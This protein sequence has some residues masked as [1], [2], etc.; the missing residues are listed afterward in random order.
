VSKQ[1]QE[2]TQSLAKKKKKPKPKNNNK[3]F[4]CISS[5]LQARLSLSLL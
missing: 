1:P 4:L 2:E 5:D 3:K